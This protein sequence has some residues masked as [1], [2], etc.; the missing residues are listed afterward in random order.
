MN[1]TGKEED[2]KEDH[3]EDDKESCTEGGQEDLC[4][5]PVW[6]RDYRHQGGD[7][8]YPLDVLRQ[9]HEAQESQG[10]MLS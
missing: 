10:K 8:R 1:H 4:M 6:N 5:R 3:E 9:N 2:R 7:G